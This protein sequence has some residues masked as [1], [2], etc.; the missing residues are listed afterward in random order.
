MVYVKTLPKEIGDKLKEDINKTSI[1]E[2][3]IKKSEGILKG[4]IKNKNK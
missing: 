1:N 2:D 3:L 4:L